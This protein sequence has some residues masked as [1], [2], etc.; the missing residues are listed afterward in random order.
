MSHDANE[1]FGSDR[2]RYK[3]MSFKGNDMYTMSSKLGFESPKDMY[4]KY[5]LKEPP[6]LF[7]LT[8][9]GGAFRSS[10]SNAYKN[11][12]RNYGLKLWLKIYISKFC[13]KIF[14]QCFQS[15]HLTVKLLV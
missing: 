14:K 5:P 8:L 7:V 12:L 9:K 2:S 10:M 6:K 4:P 3:V 15:L 13:I 11:T 1:S